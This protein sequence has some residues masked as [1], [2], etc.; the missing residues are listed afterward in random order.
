MPNAKKSIE[1]SNTLVLVK[2]IPG[3]NCEGSLK[4][5]PITIPSNKPTKMLFKK[6]NKALIVQA[7]AAI[8][9][10]KNIPEIKFFEIILQL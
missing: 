4:K 8:K 5:F 3:D 6:G 1:N 2:L 7:K 10:V 9:Q